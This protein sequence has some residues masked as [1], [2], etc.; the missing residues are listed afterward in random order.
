MS[1][2]NNV[3]FFLK[4]YSMTRKEREGKGWGGKAINSSGN[5]KKMNHLVSTV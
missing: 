5:S 1:M 3:C 4:G 2:A